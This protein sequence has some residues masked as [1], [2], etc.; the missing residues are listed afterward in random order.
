[1]TC[2]KIAFLQRTPANFFTLKGYVFW[3]VVDSC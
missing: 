1:M 2:L 3:C